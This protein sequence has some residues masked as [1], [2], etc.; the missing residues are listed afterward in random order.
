MVTIK[1]CKEIKIT[2]PPNEWRSIPY[3]TNRQTNK[4]STIFRKED[5]LDGKKRERER[6]RQT[7]INMRSRE[8]HR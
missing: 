3:N 2:A 8:K 1:C 5:I 6:D 7:E 4:A